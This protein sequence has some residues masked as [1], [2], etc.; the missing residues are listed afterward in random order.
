MSASVHV[1]P[2]AQ[3]RWVWPSWPAGLYEDSSGYH[4]DGG[5]ALDRE[6]LDTAIRALELNG[7]ALLDD[8]VDDGSLELT[9][10]DMAGVVAGLW[11]TDEYAESALT[12]SRWV[13]LFRANGFSVDGKSAD[14]PGEPVRLFR[15]C[16]P[17]V[18]SFDMNRRLIPTDCY[19]RPVVPD[20]DVIS[21]SWS[22][23]RGM[24]WTSDGR[25][26]RRFARRYRESVFAATVEPAH[27]LAVIGDTHIVDPAGLADV[28]P[29]DL[30]IAAVTR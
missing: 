28:A 16:I 22:T 12:R 9:R 2:I 6:A 14:R 27:L 24:S 21:E 1:L 18:L 8:L 25:R 10:P 13:A 4:F 5:D 15:S 17:L 19:G 29:V 20:G 23:T 26:A 3:R 7:P 30:D 11:A